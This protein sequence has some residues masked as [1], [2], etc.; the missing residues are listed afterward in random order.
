MIINQKKVLH[1]LL[2]S[3]ANVNLC[4][5]EGA[6]PLHMGAAVARDPGLL[7]ML[8][9]YGAFINAQDMYRETPMH[10]AARADNVIA[11][12][13]L[14]QLGA[15]SRARNARNEDVMQV[16]EKLG[17]KNVVRKLREWRESERLRSESQRNRMDTDE[18]EEEEEEEEDEEEEEEEDEEEED[19][20]EDKKDR[21][22]WWLN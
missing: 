11:I 2:I 4:T 20:N 18:E 15:D 16:A 9:Q 22:F 7:M 8:V 13:T 1:Y 10:W 12:E 21:N 17:R 6:T 5:S 19:D 3:G 14:L